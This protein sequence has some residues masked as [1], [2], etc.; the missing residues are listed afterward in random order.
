MGAACF[1]MAE[2]IGVPYS[3]IM[4]AGIIPAVLYYMS[5]FIAVHLRA[6]RLGMVGLPK[7][8]CPRRRKR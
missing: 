7:D 6:K 4:L 2:Y 8:H 3:K 5:A 1:V